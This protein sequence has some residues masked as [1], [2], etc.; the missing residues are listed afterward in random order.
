MNE[1]RVTQGTLRTSAG[2]VLP[3]ERT[4]V[5]A[6][7]SGPVATVRVRQVFRNTSAVPIEAVY[8]FPL[9][10]EASVF[11]M[12][13]RIGG[14]TVRGVVKEKEE[15]KRAYERARS[16]GRAATLLEQD[17]P[18]LFTLSAANVPP[19]QAIEVTLAYQERLAFD[20]GEW[21]FVFPMVAPERYAPGAPAGRAGGT[22]E[23]PDLGRVRPPSVPTGERSADVSVVV[24]VEAEHGSEP[25]SPSHRLAV[26]SLGPKRWRVR[27]HP[28]ETL[29]NRDFVLAFRDARRGVRADAHFERQAGR[30]GT[31][32]LVVRPPSV[33]PE[34]LAAGKRAPS[35]EGQALTCGNCGGAMRDAG[36]LVT[37]PEIGPAWRCSYCGVMVAASAERVTD[38][39]SL[40]RDVIILV[41][42]SRSMR[43]GSL[44]QARRVVARVLEELDPADAVQLVAFDHERVALDGRGDG[45]APCEPDLGRR[46]AAFLAGLKARGGTELEQA[47][48]RAAKLPERPGRVRV[49]V[50]ITDAALGNEGRLL[51]KAGAIVAPPRARLFVLGVGPSVNRYLVDKLARVGGGA[52]DVL[53]PG[54]DV[55]VVA[56]RF[57]RRVGQA[58]PVL[59]NLRLEW[60]DAMPADVYPSP[61]PDLFGGQP[62]QLLGRFT[63]EG[64][65]RLVL[66]GE[67]AQGRPFRQEI[68]VRLP[69]ASD[70]VPG[71]ERLWARARI[72]ARLDR[73]A[74]APDEAGD[75]RAEVLGLALRHGLM[76][77]YTALIAEDSEVVGD[78]ARPPQRVDVPAAPPAERFSSEDEETGVSELS[79]LAPGLA[80]PDGAARARASAAGV[81]AVRGMASFEEEGA[82]G[83]GM[84]PGAP[85]PP[86]PAGFA[87][88]PVGAPPVAAG[89]APPPPGAPPAMARYA[90][91]PA[92]GAPSLGAP[93]APSPAFAPPGVSASFGAPPAPAAYARPQAPEMLSPPAPP[94]AFGG[95]PPTGAPPPLGAPT[96]D[97]HMPRAAPP[98]DAARSRMAPPSPGPMEPRAVS[99]EV[100]RS[101]RKGGLLGRV[102]DFVGSIVGGGDD[103]EDEEMLPPP[104]YPPPP[105]PPPVGAYPAPAAARGGTGYCGACGASYDAASGPAFCAR[106]GARLAAPH[107]RPTTAP[108]PAQQTQTPERPRPTRPEIEPYPAEVIA[109]SRGRGVG[110][111]DLVFLVDETG[112][113]GPYIAQVKARLLELV[114][115]LRASP[116]ARSLR[117]GLVTFRDHPPQEASFVSR[118]VPLTE[119]VEAIR[120]AVAS[121]VASGGGDGPEALTDGLVDL[122]R[123]DWRPNAA[124]VAVLVGDAP[125]HGVE[126]GGDGFPEGCPC[127]QHWYTQAESCREMGVV[128]HALGCLPTL[129]AS[130][131]GAEEVFR[132]VAKTTRGMYLPLDQA[133]RLVPLVAAVA[134]AEIDRQRITEHVAD[135]VTA[136]RAL[137]APS[138]DAERVR[139]VTDVLREARVRPRSLA[140]PVGDVALPSLRFR[141]LEPADV[142][143]ALEQ[144]RRAERVSV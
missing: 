76:S 120:R 111:L 44:E 80:A 48:E 62:V 82:S 96:P 19:G 138:D 85:P 40:P 66:R 131:V 73:L 56:G 3:L 25:R 55:E 94:P 35:G 130:Y 12:V 118:S 72:E 112:S 28:S 91:P 136:Y 100:A 26:D 86:G 98:A 141:D 84:R 21:R 126:P 33:D 16:E 13:M 71:L 42:R 15:A 34:A 137:L 54:E 31:F 11:E 46:A 101:A 121:M 114:D 20:D 10:H 47:L 78:P 30:P 75:V 139:F 36:S 89:Y 132:T 92:P 53:L 32:L 115:T 39:G 24:D 140:A 64:P 1:E 51:R 107:A 90:P 69:A 14:R 128:V 123:L 79:S 63:G 38:R 27:L 60:D 43:G 18:N 105:H 70:E 133:Y 113:M 50:L 124:R 74:Q 67:T 9:P 129:R 95:L 37:L 49:V 68:D 106:C 7:V 2:V 122:V 5:E 8:L 52:S 99:S 116:L 97:E 17:R 127:G 23:V 83:G 6:K 61:L 119:D 57:A 87:R 77:P 102:A 109:W 108:P 4:E 142:E 110:D 88:P 41:D 135:V 104:P 59:R 58:G 65:S 45:W 143:A 22:S 144:L 29:P 134:E 103:D 81:G 125:P 93:P 117:L